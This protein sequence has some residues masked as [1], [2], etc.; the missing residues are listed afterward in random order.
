[1]NSINAQSILSAKVA[2]LSGNSSSDIDDKMKLYV[3][4]DTVLQQ[5]LA[6][7]EAFWHQD[8]DSI[9]E[10]P[11]SGLDA[12]FYQMLFQAQSVQKI[13]PNVPRKN[14]WFKIIQHWL[15][16][17]P[18]MQFA[19]MAAVFTLGYNI[20]AP[21]VSET[22]NTAM[23]GLQQKV[24]SL[25]SLVALSMINNR[26]ASKRLTGIDYSRQSTIDDNALNEALLRMLKH[27]SSTAVRLSVVNALAERGLSDKSQQQLLE[28]LTL[29]KPLVQI[30]LVT[31]LLNHGN[32]TSV[33]TLA[34]LVETQ[35]L[36][37]EA[38]EI[39]RQH[40]EQQLRTKQI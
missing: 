19:M 20:N 23:Q 17:K 31:L 8:N 9:E 33:T 16:P 24:E 26:S 4:D 35:K 25:N 22:N 34:T 37:T 14:A 2:F 39:Y 6:F 15:T 1:M 29:Q 30:E 27:D 12:Q 38:I 18:I 5:E 40:I 36:S 32:S 28:G 3:K 10:K 21:T 7:I 13:K 11:S